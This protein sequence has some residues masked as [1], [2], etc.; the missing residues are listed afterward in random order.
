[1]K[2][3]DDLIRPWVRALVAKGLPISAH[4]YTAMAMNSYERDFVLPALSDEALFIK[5]QYT[6]N[7][8]TP[9]QRGPDTPAAHYD[10]AAIYKIIPELV[11]RL[12]ERRC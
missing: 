2:D 10:E 11:R 8:C 6:L 9:P 12:K 3:N 5:I 1:M 4:D 7:N